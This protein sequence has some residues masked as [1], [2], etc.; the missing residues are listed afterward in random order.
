MA[1]CRARGGGY[2]VHPDGATRFTVPGPDS[3]TTQSR[4]Y[5]LEPPGN[6]NGNGGGGGGGGSGGGGGGGC[7]AG[8]MDHQG[9]DLT[10]TGGCD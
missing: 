2:Y 4:E 1:L 3:S 10:A 9:A 6:D 7:V 5:P 8:G